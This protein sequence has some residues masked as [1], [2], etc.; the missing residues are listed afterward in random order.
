MLGGSFILSGAVN[1]LSGLSMTSHLTNAGVS[2][3]V[4]VVTGAAIVQLLM[5]STLDINGEVDSL[6]STG[7]DELSIKT[8][9]ESAFVTKTMLNSAI[10]RLAIPWCSTLAAWATS[11]VIAALT[12]AAHFPGCT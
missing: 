5:L 3:V 10:P 1:I 7:L 2:L 12:T 9:I 11:F 8:I 4:L 6:L